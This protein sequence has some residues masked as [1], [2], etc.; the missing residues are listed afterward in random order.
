MPEL[1]PQPDHREPGSP[2]SIPKPTAAPIASVP[3]SPNPAPSPAISEPPP[4]PAPTRRV[5][6][7]TILG[8]LTVVIAAL[9]LIPQFAQWLAAPAA[10][11]IASTA[12]A[13]ATPQPIVLIVATPTPD[14]AN[15]PITSLAALQTVA[16]VPPTT[17]ALTFAL[18]TD[19]PAT[20]TRLPTSTPVPFPVAT[21]E[22]A[23]DRSG[24][25]FGIVIIDLSSGEQVYQ[26]NA[27]RVFPAASVIKLAI[28]L[29]VYEQA[30]RAV[31]DLDEMLTI[32]SG[33]IVGGTGS[34]QHG[35]AGRSY[36]IRYL[37]QLMLSESDNTAGN[38]LLKRIGVDTVNNLLV[39]IGADQTRVQRLFMDLAAIQAGRDNLTSPSDMA[40]LL[41]LIAE[42]ELIGVDGG[43]ALRTALAQSIDTNKLPA[44]LPKDAVVAHKSGTL[45]GVEHDVAIITP[46]GQSVGY[47]CVMLSADLSTNA[48]G[49]ATIARASEIAYNWA[50]SRG[51]S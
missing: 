50:V 32:S 18:P 36:T 43:R 28:A 26:R 11:V 42:D 4:L 22:Q 19:A 33:D 47:L 39:Q 24:G 25:T 46:P 21:F 9:A 2:S 7:E 41:T 29:T 40:L 23:L 30:Q 16:P 13:V 51:R 49:I 48:D 1:R 15:V 12:T 38:V 3:R 14:P 45:P 34:L 17:I 8:V 35:G 20:A 27:D 10:P 6:L 31:L 37:C 5:P 44:H